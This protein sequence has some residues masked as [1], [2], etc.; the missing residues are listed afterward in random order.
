MAPSQHPQAKFDPIPP[1]LDLNALVEK[2]Q[3]FQWVQ[4][5]T[6]AQIRS[7]RVEDFE[8][9]VKVHV[10]QRGKP[11][12]IEQWNDRLPKPLFSAKWLESTYDKRRA[13]LALP[14][15]WPTEADC[16]CRGECPRYR[17]PDRHPD[18]DWPLPAFDETAH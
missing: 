7:I 15:W 14:V 6:A 10:I 17:F 12:V 11:L 3:N 18:D 2:T 13:S 4:R 1:D 5:I 16:L 8:N 9:L